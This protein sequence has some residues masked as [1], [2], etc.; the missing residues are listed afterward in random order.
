MTATAPKYRTLTVL[1][2]QRDNTGDLFVINKNITDINRHVKRSRLV[3][4]ID[5]NQSIVVEASFIPQNL[6]EWD[7][8]ELM[9]N[10]S[11][12]KK[13]VMLGLLEIVHPEDARKLLNQPLAK[14]EASRLFALRTKHVRG[15]AFNG[16]EQNVSTNAP[17]NNPN[18]NLNEEREDERMCNPVMLNHLATAENEN[19]TME[20]VYHTLKTLSDDTL[21]IHDWS[22]IVKWCDERNWAKLSRWGQRG[23]ERHLAKAQAPVDDGSN[24]DE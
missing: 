6:A 2:S 4:N 13:T 12:F 18:S 23:V 20:A 1:E 21:T 9:C 5:E 22:Y 10:S 16:P 7:N 14:E 3:V 11:N 17:T 15:A 24:F 8:K 19:S